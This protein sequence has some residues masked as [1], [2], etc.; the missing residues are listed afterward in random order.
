MLTNKK[1]IIGVFLASLGAITIVNHVILPAWNGS[2]LTGQLPGMPIILPQSFPPIEEFSSSDASSSKEPGTTD[3][4]AGEPAM[5]IVS[6]GGDVFDGCKDYEKIFPM[7]D[8]KSVPDGKTLVD[9]V[10]REIYK[11][12][13]DRIDQ[14]AFP[15]DSTAPTGESCKKK[16]RDMIADLMKLMKQ[17]ECAL[18]EEASNTFEQGGRVLTEQRRAKNNQEPLMVL[19]LLLYSQTESQ[20]I[21]LAM[22]AIKNTREQIL[23]PTYGR[24]PSP[25]EAEAETSQK[26]NKLLEKMFTLITKM[27]EERQSSSRAGGGDGTGDDSSGDTTPPDESGGG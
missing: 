11:R 8:Y 21:D 22:S 14:D 5:G 27:S 7:D 1:R 19:D 13:S 3:Q 4:A 26:M 2:A 20:Q 16:E 17:Y 18:T 15:K 9:G 24:C 23:S 6:G 12:E 25:K 10:W